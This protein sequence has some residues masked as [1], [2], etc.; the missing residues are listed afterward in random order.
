MNSFI[1]SC[2]N[3][4]NRY[5]E[6]SRWYGALFVVILGPLVRLLA[7][8]ICFTK[9]NLDRVHVSHLTLLVL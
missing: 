3:V 4:N 9:I 7:I 6:Q 2:S 8:E 1:V 5:I